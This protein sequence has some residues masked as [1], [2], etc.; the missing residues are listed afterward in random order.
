M[1]VELVHLSHGLGGLPVASAPYVRMCPLLGIGE[2][3][4]RRRETAKGERDGLPCSL[5][6]QTWGAR[7]PHLPRQTA[8]EGRLLEGFKSAAGGH[9]QHHTKTF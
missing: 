5:P 1:V 9:S 3:T 2:E 7:P 4:G 8:V 6:G